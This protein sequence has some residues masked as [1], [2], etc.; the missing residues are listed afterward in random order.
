MNFNKL[1]DGAVSITVA[2]KESDNKVE[3][4]SPR[5]RVRA[6]VKPFLFFFYFILFFFFFFFLLSQRSR[7]FFAIYMFAEKKN[8]VLMYD[9]HVKRLHSVK[10]RGLYGD[11][12]TMQE[13]F[14]KTCTSSA[15]GKK[16]GM[17]LSLNCVWDRTAAI[18]GV[19]RSTAQKVVE[20]KKKA[21]DEQQQLKQ[22]PSS[23]SKVS[24]DDFNQGVVQRTIANMYSLKK[25]LSTLD[26]IRTE[27][28]QTIGYTVSN[29]HLRK[30][31][32]HKKFAYTHC[33]VNQKVLM[34]RQDVVLSR[35]RYLRMVGDLREAGYTDETYWQDSTTE[36]KIPFSKVILRIVE[37]HD[38]WVCTII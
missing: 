10:W 36:L 3:G 25:V 5:L 30:D 32:L 18:F 24:L 20:E 27:H 21:Q 12:A 14:L 29:G 2:L 17:K 13:L 11:T 4:L 38:P 35:I 1:F 16:S 19:S 34:E 28:K 6:P 8:H 23:T 31:L 22:P 33:V 7:Q 37:L 15:W 9:A 26:N